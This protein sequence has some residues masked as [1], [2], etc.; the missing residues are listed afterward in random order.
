MAATTLQ[1][2]ETSFTDAKID[3]ILRT[4]NDPPL[5]FRRLRGLDKA[6]QTDQGELTNN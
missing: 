3:D 4:I 2:L 6:Q 5:N 1:K